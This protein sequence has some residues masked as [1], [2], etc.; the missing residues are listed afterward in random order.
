MGILN[1]L[2]R[3]SR[4]ADTAVRI[5]TYHWT[6]SSLIKLAIAATV[7]VGTAAVFYVIDSKKEGEII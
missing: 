4:I 7:L 2:E 3:T 1:T 5:S 6:K